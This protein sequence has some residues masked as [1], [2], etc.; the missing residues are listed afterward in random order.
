MSVLYEK[1]LRPA[2]FRLSPETAH[3]F[4]IEALRRGIGSKLARTLA[5]RRFA[6]G[7]SFGGIER[8]GL[9]FKNP[10]GVAAGFDKNGVVVEQLAVLG[11]GF[12]EVGTVTLNPQKGNDKPRLFRL[13]A[14]GALVNRLGF[15]NDGTRRVVERLKR[16]RPDCVVGVNIGKNKDVPNDAAIENY[17]KSFE[18][19]AP[20]ADYVAVNVSSPN[21]PNLRELQKADSLEELLGA[22]QRRNRELYGKPLLVKIAPDLTDAEIEAIA[23]IAADLD[24][25]GIIAT[26]TTVSRA[27]LKTPIDEAG[28]LS[29]K[30]L[31]ARSTEVIEKIFRF[32]RGEIPIVGVGG[33]FSAADAFEKIAAGACLVEAY[34]GFVYGGLA[35]AREL[36]RGLARLLAERGF[37]TLDEAVGS[38]VS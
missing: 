4:G 1:L 5:A 26:N 23:G 31:R 15:N 25:A 8:F 33:I 13:P 19:A 32:S 35:F 10:L 27:G 16:I 34:T 11:F 24:L 7:E 9:K 12:V 28:G 30:P 20:V 36:N 3:E 2:L 17:L 37:K 21:T 29:G 22:L 18:L 14:D 6:V 38:A